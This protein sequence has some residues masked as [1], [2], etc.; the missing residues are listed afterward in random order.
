MRRAI[1]A[2][3]GPLISAALGEPPLVSPMRALVDEG[4][5]WGVRAVFSVSL[6]AVGDVA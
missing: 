3:S 6:M 2:R 5:S 4:W 1:G